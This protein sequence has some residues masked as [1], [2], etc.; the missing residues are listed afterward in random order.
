[1]KQ[2]MIQ[3][4]DDFVEALAVSEEASFIF[5]E[6]VVKTL[7]SDQATLNESR[8]SLELVNGSLIKKGVDDVIDTLV[9]TPVE[10][11]EPVNDVSDTKETDGEES[12]E[13]EIIT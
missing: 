6:D 2:V 13:E 9:E 12:K 4:N 5:M 10:E 1:M 11:V 7:N 3:L 8:C